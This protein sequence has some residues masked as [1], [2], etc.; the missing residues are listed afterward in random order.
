MRR[1]NLGI[2]V[3]LVATLGL[4]ACSSGSGDDAAPTAS[5]AVTIS[6]VPAVAGAQRVTVLGVGIDVPAGMTSNETTLDSGVHQ[7]VVTQP[8]QQRAVAV[9]SVTPEQG[10]TNDK[11]AASAAGE[12]ATLGSSGKATK[13][14]RETAAWPGFPFA[15]Q[16]TGVLTLDGGDRDF[17]AL[18]T[19]DDAGTKIVSVSTDAPAGQ[20]ETSPGWDVLRTVRVDG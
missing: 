12:M 19:R 3:A 11:V 4:T 9:V 6:P 20:L 15:V 17:V 1:L 5:P 2:T 18:T 8:G 7:L 10:T 14:A 16:V 13:L